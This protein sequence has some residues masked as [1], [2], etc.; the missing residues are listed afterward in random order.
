MGLVS[1]RPRHGRLADI[2]WF[3]LLQHS[4]IGR[5]WRFPRLTLKQQYLFSLLGYTSPCFLFIYFLFFFFNSLIFRVIL[6]DYSQ[7]VMTNLDKNQEI[8][9]LCSA[10]FENR[11]FR[12]STICFVE[13]HFVEFGKIPVSEIRQND[14]VD[15]FVE[16]H[17]PWKR[18][19]NW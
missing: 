8:I 14:F 7:F 17:F 18:H 6:S 12:K 16:I 10:E 3:A 19:Q 4:K 13:F 15:F 11:T 9:E 5:H 1:Q 2:H